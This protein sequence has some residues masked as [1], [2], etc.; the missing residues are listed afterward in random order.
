MDDDTDLSN[1]AICLVGFIVFCIIFNWLYLGAMCLVPKNLPLLASFVTLPRW[2][3]I[4]I[5][6]AVPVISLLVITGFDAWRDTIALF[7][8]GWGIAYCILSV[9]VFIWLVSPWSS[10]LIF[11]VSG[12]LEGICGINFVMGLTAIIVGVGAAMWVLEG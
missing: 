5:V 6:I 7:G 12:I 1:P 2:A 8:N 10:I 4:T 11:L 9:I 3:E